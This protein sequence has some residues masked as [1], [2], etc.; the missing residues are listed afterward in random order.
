MA[1]KDGHGMVSLGE[2]GKGR[3]GEAWLGSDRIG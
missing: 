3:H 1:G 2:V